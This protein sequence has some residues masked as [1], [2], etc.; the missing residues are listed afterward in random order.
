[1]KRIAKEGAL[2]LIL[3]L[4]TVSI[5]YTIRSRIV[6]PADVLMQ[7]RVLEQELLEIKSQLKQ[8][9]GLSERVN[10]NHRLFGELIPLITD[11]IKLQKQQLGIPTDE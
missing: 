1:M 5:S 8:I 10:E 7:T 9:Q 3:V 6:V 2:V 11:V 4:V